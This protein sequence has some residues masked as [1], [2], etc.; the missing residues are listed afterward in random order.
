LKFRWIIWISVIIF[1]WI[2]LTRLTEIEHVAETLAGGDWLW[3]LI[4]AA[5]QVLYYTARSGLYRVTF[6]SIGVESRLAELLPVTFA[7]LFLNVTAPSGGA[8]GAALFVDYARRRGQSGARAAVGALLVLTADFIAFTLVL[9]AGMAFLFLAHDL[10][11]YQVTA[12][13]LLLGLTVGLSAL[14]ALGLWAPDRL[15][16]VLDG[17]LRLAKRLGA[18]LHRPKLVPNRHVRRI[19]EEFAEAAQAISA[20]PGNL[21]RILAVALAMHFVDLL[22]L[23][24]L[25]Q[26]FGQPLSLGVIVAGYAMGLL[27]WIVSIPPQGIGVVEGAMTLVFTSL[28]LTGERAAVIAISFR[29]LTFWLPLV[30]G[31]LLL[32]RVRA[33]TGEPPPPILPLGEDEED[34]R[35]V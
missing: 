24:A 34:A 8:S 4:A 17:M 35:R 19:T 15:G 12:A 27:F 32:R 33:F 21:G 18:L 5:I 3:V 28:G 22:S 1:L 6:A 25:F 14:M 20:R 9:A 26:A 10:R 11:F 29:G 30:A 2:V 13:I 23:A 7:S 16:R 31:F